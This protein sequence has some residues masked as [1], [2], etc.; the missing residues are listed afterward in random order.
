MAPA[1]FDVILD[2]KE[3][4]RLLNEIASL[5][6]SA[7]NEKA[8]KDR[9]NALYEMGERA[10]DLADLMTRDKEAHGAIDTNLGQI[11]ERRLRQLGVVMTLDKLGYHYDLAVFK[12]YLRRAPTGERAADA[13]YVLIG[14][15]EPGEDALKLERS[16]RDKEQFLRQYPKFTEMSVVKLL[17][18]Q[19]HIRLG[20]AYKAQKR[21]AAADQQQKMAVEM[22]RE[23]VRLYPQSQEAETASDYLNQL[24]VK[25]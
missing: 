8:E 19:Q 15:D 23:I 20:R 13:R 6:E 9:L 1:F 7:K 18:A 22:Y 3:V 24:G 2:P 5:Q 11:I 17:L 12:E 21:Q 10:L 14:F 25:P 4:N 16:I